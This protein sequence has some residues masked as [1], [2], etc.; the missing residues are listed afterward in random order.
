VSRRD[1][2]SQLTVAQVR[3]A[4]FSDPRNQ[5]RLEQIFSSEVA[6]P[7][8]VEHPARAAP[9]KTV[10][11]IGTFVTPLSWS[12]WFLVWYRQRIVLG[13]DNEDRQQAG[14]LFVARVL[15]DPVMGTGQFVK[16][17]ACMIDLGRVIADLA[18]DGAGQH[19][20]IDKCRR[21]VAMGQRLPPGRIIHHHSNY[22]LSF[23]IWE[24]VLK[25]DCHL[26]LVLR[27]GG[28]ASK[29]YRCCY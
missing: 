22:S 19:I 7:T 26:I 2:G 5:F 13:I 24:C 23:D 28:R 20:G 14:G 21:C 27:D 11:A 29:G 8:A 17:F 12:P 16:T 15:A 1:V 3:F 10:M 18:A 25:D 9:K 6:I 4:P